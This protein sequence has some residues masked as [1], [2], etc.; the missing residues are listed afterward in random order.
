MWK[1]RILKSS[2]VSNVLKSSESEYQMKKKRIDLLLI[3]L[4]NRAVNG[5][6]KKKD[7]KKHQELAPF[8]PLKALGPI[9]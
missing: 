1:D 3:N 7:Q 9:K 8:E 6:M 4:I 2:P 5:S